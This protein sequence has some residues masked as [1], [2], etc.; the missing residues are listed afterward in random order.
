MFEGSMLER[1]ARSYHAVQEKTADEYGALS[2]YS[3]AVAQIESLE[4]E[5]EGGVGNGITLHLD[6]NSNNFKVLMSYLFLML[7]FVQVHYSTAYFKPDV[8]G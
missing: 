7:I 1:V 2:K 3:A 6:S 8:R 5:A 4:K